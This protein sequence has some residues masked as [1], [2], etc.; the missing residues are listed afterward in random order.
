ML[1]FI[2]FEKQ[3]EMLPISIASKASK[4]ENFYC[5][6][7]DIHYADNHAGMK[8]GHMLSFQK[9]ELAIRVFVV[10]GG[11]HKR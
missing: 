8:R 7:P 2:K 6:S 5:W 3:K 9:E 10:W 4:V 11:T 1:L